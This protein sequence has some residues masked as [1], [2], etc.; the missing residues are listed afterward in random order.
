[1]IRAWHRLGA[2][3]VAVAVAACGDEEDLP[4]ASP[5]PPCGAAPGLRA[6]GTVPAGDAAFVV[7]AH[8]CSKRMLP[9]DIQITDS[10][11][12]VLGVELEPLEDGG[13]ELLVRTEPPLVPGTYRVITPDGRS[14]SLTVTEPAALPTTLGELTLKS[15]SNCRRV[16]DLALDEGAL[17][18]LSL[19][20]TDTHVSPGPP[21]APDDTLWS[22]VS[23]GR[24]EVKDRHV[25]LDI[26]YGR[27]K[28]WEHAVEMRAHIAGYDA[29]VLPAGATM[30]WSC[31]V[32]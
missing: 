25:T 3:A 1:V 4:D 14:Q 8:E 6:F 24:L 17:A 12:T 11:G 27:W 22:R 32:E 9:R 29:E 26:S 13:A 18:Y 16:F 30:D 21:L 23:P 28:P 19:M 7:Y 31:A 5:W 2:F 20:G 10:S 15:Q